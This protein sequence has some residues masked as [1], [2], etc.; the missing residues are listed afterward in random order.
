MKGLFAQVV[1]NPTVGISIPDFREHPGLSLAPLAQPQ[2][3][4]EFAHKS[5]LRYND[6]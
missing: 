2:S 4:R 1:L 3:E 5:I 6:S